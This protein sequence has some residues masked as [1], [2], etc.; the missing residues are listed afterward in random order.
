M[1]YYSLMRPRIIRVMESATTTM[2]PIMVLSLFRAPL[3]QVCQMS[4]ISAVM[5]FMALQPLS[6][7]TVSLLSGHAEIGA[8]IIFL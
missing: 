6:G 1:P 3:L 7:E 5:L 4:L 8:G 2:N